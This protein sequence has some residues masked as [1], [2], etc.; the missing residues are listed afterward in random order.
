MRQTCAASAGMTILLDRYGG[1]RPL[2]G[3]L[4]GPSAV[5]HLRSAILANVLARHVVDD[6]HVVLI[7]RAV[8]HQDHVARS[9]ILELVE[10]S[11]GDQRG[12]AGLEHRRGAVRKMHRALA[13]ETGEDL[14]L[15]V[16]MHVIMVARIGIVM[17]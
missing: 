9:R 4:L 15:V 3:F 16:A 11:A 2:A 5:A 7:A 13:F 10:R 6:H 12:H 14:I 17:Y 1:A 8:A